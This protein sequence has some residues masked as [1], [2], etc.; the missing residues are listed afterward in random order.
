[1]R[2][3][4]SITE[5]HASVVSFSGRIN[6]PVHDGHRMMQV[7]VVRCVEDR[8]MGRQIGCFVSAVE[9]NAVGIEYANEPNKHEVHVDVNNCWKNY[10]WQCTNKLTRP[11]VCNDSK[12]GWIVE[13]MMMP[14]HSPK[15]IESMTQVVRRVFIDVSKANDNESLNKVTPEPNIVWITTVAAHSEESK[16]LLRSAIHS[17]ARQI[18]R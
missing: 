7:V 5:I 14:M 18:E 3:I 6:A 2:S 15:D 4:A 1:M 13:R 11:I 10:Y 17:H 8:V 9:V 12:W 16:I